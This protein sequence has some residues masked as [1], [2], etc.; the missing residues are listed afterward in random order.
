MEQDPG[1]RGA[2]GASA[3]VP[4]GLLEGHLVFGAA[5]HPWLAQTRFQPHPSAPAPGPWDC[6]LV[7]VLF[8]VI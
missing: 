4:K 8:E 5:A 3:G 1:T 7:V 6:T 2:T